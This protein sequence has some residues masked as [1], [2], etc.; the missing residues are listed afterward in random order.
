[1]ATMNETFDSAV[2]CHR[3]GDLH[4]AETLYRQAL[5]LDP[6]HAHAHYNLGMVLKVQGRLDE[7]AVCYRQVLLLD[8]VN[9]NAHINLG[10]IL[11]EQ[12]QAAEAV[13]CYRQAAHNVPLFTEAHIN[14]GL[15]L[16]EQG[17]LAEAAAS[18]RRALGTNP[19]NAEAHYHLGVALRRL[20]QMAE[21]VVCFQ[22]ALRANPQLGDAYINL[23]D[24]LKELGRLP[25]AVGSYG[26]ALRINPQH[27]E[28]HNNLGN[29]FELQG[30]PA[31]AIECYRRA[32]AINFHQADT[33]YNLGIALTQ[34]GMFREA[35]EHNEQ[36]LRINPAHTRALWNRALLRL[37]EGDF[38]GGWQD[39]ELRWSQSDMVPRYWRQPRWDGSPLEGKS[40]LVHAEQGLGD[41]IQFVRYLTMVQERGGRVLFECQSE[42]AQ[43]F[44]GIA[45]ADEIVARGAPLPPH[46]LQVPLLSLPGIFGTTLASIPAP[47]PYLRA[48]AGLVDSWRSKLEPV[49]GFK[50]GIAWQG[51]QI[52]KEDRFRSFPLAHFESVARVPGVRLVSLQV[53]PGTEQLP[54]VSFPITDLGSKFDPGSLGDLAAALMNMDL[55]VTADTA[56]AHLAGAVGIPVWVLVPMPPDWRWLLDRSDSP[57]YPTMR[58]F[59]Q[60]QFGD[61]SEVFERVALEAVAVVEKR[62]TGSA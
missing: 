3:G 59:R 60:T 43:L 29:T 25:E 2:R 11:K 45:G 47:V 15:A 50:V 35:R 8:P 36:A 5:Q 23:G 12:G 55:V 26:H 49:V 20:G 38:A 33:H 61:W 32:L 34:L 30:E 13:E 58:L 18:Y 24:A 14:L 28:A 51:R 19:R 7:A 40:I 54:A 56:V 31:L 39:Y 9:A 52:H 37:L 53:G 4:Q 10:N 16:V 62:G 1:M 57:W 17:K 42:L 48:D 22:Q 6:K 21:A 46:D 41:T 27:L 44:R